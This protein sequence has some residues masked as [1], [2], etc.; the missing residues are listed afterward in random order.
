MD[1]AGLS[2]RILVATGVLAA[3]TVQQLVRIL[4]IVVVLALIW[5]AL[6]YFLRLAW[7]VFS[8]GCGLIVLVGLVLLGL[9]FFGR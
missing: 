3:P 8:C 9:S 7:R 2:S 4:A 5:L 1:V 6:R